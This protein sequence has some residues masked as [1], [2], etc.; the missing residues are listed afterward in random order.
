MPFAG[1][2]TLAGHLADLNKFRGVPELEEAYTYFTTT[3]KIEQNNQKC[4]T[5][6]IIHFQILFRYNLL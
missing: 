1:R 5:G 4:H 3:D 2:Y 6:G